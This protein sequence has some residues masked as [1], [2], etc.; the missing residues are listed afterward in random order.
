MR[1]SHLEILSEN[2]SQFNRDAMEHG[3]TVTKLFDNIVVW[4]VGFATG[5]IALILAS[6]DKIKFLNN[7]TVNVTVGILVAAI[8]LGILGRVLY[9]VATYIGSQLMQLLNFQIVM[10]TFPHANKPLLGTETSEEVYHILQEDF[11]LDLPSILEDRKKIPQENLHIYDEA[12]KLLYKDYFEWS[13]ASYD[14]A[15]KKI[16]KIT[17]DT[18]GLE[19][20]HFEKYKETKKWK[21]KMLRFTTTAS[22]IIYILAILSFGTA[23][24][25]FFCQ[26]VKSQ[27]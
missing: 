24:L 12:A 5:A 26:Y 15:M 6:L 14:D 16:N 20:N 8:C 21:G 19:E 7:R 22:Y 2:F 27:P 1:K 11:K 25:Y 3:K 23:I 17:I 18:L 4:I 9:A 13:Q 10:L